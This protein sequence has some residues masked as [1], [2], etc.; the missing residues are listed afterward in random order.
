MTGLETGAAGLS[1]G[2]DD[3]DGTISEEKIAHLA[4]AATPVG[5]AREKMEETIRTAGFRPV[6]RDGVFSPREAS[7]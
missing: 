4:G 7:A 3:M 5:L 6:E 2:A 1:W